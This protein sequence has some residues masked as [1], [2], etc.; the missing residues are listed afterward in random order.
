MTRVR[1]MLPVEFVEGLK[2]SLEMRQP[3]T[4]AVE[5]VE[6][7]TTDFEMRQTLTMAVKFVLQIGLKMSWWLGLAG[8]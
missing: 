7:L 4:M 5:F 2:T 1:V 6:D 3:L 8:R